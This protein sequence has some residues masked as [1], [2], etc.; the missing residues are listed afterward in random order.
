MASRFGATRN[1]AYFFFFAVAF[2]F[3]GAFFLALDI[4]FFFAGM[5]ASLESSLRVLGPSHHRHRP[6]QPPTTHTSGIIG[7][8]QPG[9]Q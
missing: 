3:A 5:S 7:K 2:F 6:Q 1:G 8:K 9:G 4:A